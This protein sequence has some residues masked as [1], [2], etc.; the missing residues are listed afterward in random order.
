MPSSRIGR[1]T[2]NSAEND[3]VWVR[4]STLF[5]AKFSKLSDVG[6]RFVQ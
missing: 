1:F 5:G 4:R 3:I 2:S 6:I